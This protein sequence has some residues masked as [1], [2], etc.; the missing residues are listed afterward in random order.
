MF[1][2]QRWAAAFVNS[3]GGEAH[4][5]GEHEPR[6]RL[7]IEGFAELKVLSAWVKSLPGAVFGSSAAKRLEKLIAEGAGKSG[8]PAEL[9]EK[10][11]RF[12]SLLVRKDLFKHI[13]PVLREIEK[14]LNKKRGVLPVIVESALPLD[15]EMEA[16]ISGEIKK[17]R[18]A[19]ELKLE[20]RINAEIIGGFRLRIGDE[21]IDASLRSQL[22][23]LAA[24]L[25]SGAA[26]PAA[27]PSDGGS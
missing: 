19:G 23:L 14:I 1:V 8:A 22:R 16:F 21:L 4:E 12:I 24:D 5:P 26:A 6:V 13:D 20:K 9:T 17:R 3:L 7:L 10:C 18:K 15:G 25:A 2:P 11:S 27:G